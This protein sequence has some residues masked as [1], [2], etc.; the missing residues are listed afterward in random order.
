MKKIKLLLTPLVFVLIFSSMITT[1]SVSAESKS[2]NNKVS[3]SVLQPDSAT[4]K[5]FEKA[6][7]IVK[8]DGS[9]VINI[10]GFHGK[11]DGIQTYDVEI[12]E[13]NKTYVATKMQGEELNTTKESIA[14]EVNEENTTKESIVKMENSLLA[15]MSGGIIATTDD[16]VGADLAITKHK[17]YWTSGGYDHRTGSAWGANPSS[18]GTHWYVNENRFA[19]LTTIDGGET[20]Y[21][22]LY[23][24]YYNY[25]FQSNDQRTDISHSV[26][27]Y[28]YTAGGFNYDVSWTKSGEA[29][30]LLDLDIS[31]Y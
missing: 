6:E 19:G 21:S 26:I 1:S 7:Y 4:E 27:I 3:V 17:L 24:S 31:L 2:K 8:P 29:S 23:T 11:N 16:P 30:W 28:G 20:V 25:D 5:V 9:E 18:L 14:K 22:K 13:K 10:K 12:D 15:T